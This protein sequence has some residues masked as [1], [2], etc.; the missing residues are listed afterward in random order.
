[1]ITRHV[2]AGLSFLHLVIYWTSRILPAQNFDLPHGVTVERC[3]GE[4]ANL[5]VDKGA[6]LQI[7]ISFFSGANPFFELTDSWEQQAV[8]SSQEPPTTGEML[9]ML[10]CCAGGSRLTINTAETL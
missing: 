5:D 3:L 7:P 8:C 9:A 10:I 1:M 2:P 4:L 6:I